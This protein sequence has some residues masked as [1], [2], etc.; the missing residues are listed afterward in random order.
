MQ[1]SCHQS[2]CRYDPLY[3]QRYV[4]EELD[5]HAMLEQSEEKLSTLRASHDA[6]FLYQDDVLRNATSEVAS[7]RD[8]LRQSNQDKVM[9]TLFDH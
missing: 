8:Q 9:M 6:A 7:L 4:A 3:R 1:T 5:S 2:E